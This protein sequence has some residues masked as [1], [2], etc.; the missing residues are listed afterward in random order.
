MTEARAGFGLGSIR[1]IKILIN[2]G[3]CMDIP[4][5]NFIKGKHG[6]HILN[7]GLC[8]VWG[9]TGLGNSFKSTFMH[10]MLMTAQARMGGSY[11]MIYDTE[12]NVHL[13]RLRDLYTN[14][15][16]YSDI[17]LEYDL[18]DE[19][20]MIVTDKSVYSGNK[21]YDATR[22]H[23]KTRWNGKYN[24]TTPFIDRQGNYIKMNEPAFSEVDSF[25]EFTTDA[26]EKMQDDAEIGESGQ[27]AVS[28]KS[29]QHKNQLLMELPALALK[30]D[31]YFLMTAH[32]GDEF[33]LDPKKIATKKLADLP[34]GKKLKGVPEKFTFV[35]QNCWLSS[36]AVNLLNDGTKQPEFPRN[37]EDDRKGETDVKRVTIRGLRGKSGL[38]GE[39]VTLVV[40]QT[41]GIMP[42][43]TE[44]YNIKEN[45]RFGISGTNKA[46]YPLDLY[47]EVTLSRKTV[48]GLIESDRRLRRAL[49]LTSEMQQMQEY[50]YH[51]PEV[52]VAPADVYKAV[53]EAGYDWNMILDITRGWWMLEEDHRPL[54]LFLSSYDVLMMAQGLYHPYWLESDKKT[55]KKA[56]HYQVPEEYR[57]TYLGG[58]ET[59][60]DQKAA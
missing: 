33:N 48:R 19:G 5:G 45:G 38:T 26:L 41:L 24:V 42:S 6:E 39:S 35:T 23:L 28:L 49:N 27:N 47:P 59:K 15:Y 25:T 31:A 12:M 29:G 22:E 11:S 9:V 54:G 20:S 13:W 34:S 32:L 10:Y 44:F 55:I 50:W 2:V 4:T 8:N 14:A 46:V 16:R 58:K 37:E 1:P 53:K 40:S 60:A 3:C 18:L 36:S 17:P 30:S 52:M 56:Y 51:K 43:L 57:E 21:W 7:G